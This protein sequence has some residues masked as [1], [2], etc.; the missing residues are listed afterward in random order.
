MNQEITRRHTGTNRHKTRS[1]AL[2][3]LLG[4]ITVTPGITSAQTTNF[5]FESICRSD[6]AVKKDIVTVTLHDDYHI[7]MADVTINALW[8]YVDYRQN[9]AVFKYKQTSCTTNAYGVC[10]F[11]GGSGRARWQLSEVVG[12]DMGSPAFDVTTDPT[13]CPNALMIDFW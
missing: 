1:T 5:H 12:Y 4:I 10:T 8:T 9:H 2:A 13:L 11:N 7:P 6:P 3:T